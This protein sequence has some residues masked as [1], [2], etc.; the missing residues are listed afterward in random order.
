M[1]QTT[2]ITKKEKKNDRFFHWQFLTMIKEI[3]LWLA[4]ID[5]SYEPLM[6]RINSE[7]INN[8]NLGLL[9]VH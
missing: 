3:I 5:H 4:F 2:T 6:N 9:R 7:P 8:R 1:L